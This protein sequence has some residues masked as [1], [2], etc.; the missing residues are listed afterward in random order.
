MFPIQAHWE[1]GRQFKYQAVTLLEFLK[2]E[3]FFKALLLAL[4]KL[5][6]VWHLVQI[7]EEAQQRRTVG[8]HVLQLRSRLFTVS[9][10][11]NKWSLFGALFVYYIFIRVISSSH[12]QTML[13][14]SPHTM[15]A[16]YVPLNF[17]LKARIKGTLQT[18]H[19]H[20]D[21]FGVVLGVAL[22]PTVLLCSYE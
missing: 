12:Y 1:N 3:I 6:I 9:F 16:S 11:Q 21:T 8:N 22:C 19:L 5:N 20:D 15:Q 13:C 4:K 2:L 14:Y 7:F 10:P 17:N 18:Y